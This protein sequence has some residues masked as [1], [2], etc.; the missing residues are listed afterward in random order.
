MV[1]IFLVVLLV[2]APVSGQDYSRLRIIAFGA[3]PDDCDSKAGGLAAKYASAGHLVKF[4]SVT[5]PVE[6]L[7]TERTVELQKTAFSNGPTTIK[8]SGNSLTII[9]NLFGN[10]FGVSFAGTVTGSDFTAT[11]ALS[12]GDWSCQNGTVIRHQPGTA[13][14]VGSFSSD[15]HQLTATDVHTFPLPSGEKDDYTWTWAGTRQ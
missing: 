2:A 8:R 13:R 7:V 5:S 15:G 4:V 9:S 1:L 12:G 11:G 10:F 3:H 14:A 6:C